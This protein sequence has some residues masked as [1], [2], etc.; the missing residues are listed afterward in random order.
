VDSVQD[1]KTFD[2]ISDENHSQHKGSPETEK[3]IKTR[4]SFQNVVYVRNVRG[5][6]LM[7]TTQQKASKLL[8]CGR[9]K[10]IKRSPFTIQLTY[11]CREHR[12]EIILGVDPGYENIGLSA[13]TKKE[14]VLN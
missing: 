13:T 1:L 10:V 6:P 8:K 4:K 5:K 9:A 3:S 11:E 7:G 14:E 2:N 12:Q